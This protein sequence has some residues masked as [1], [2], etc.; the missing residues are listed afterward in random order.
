MKPYFNRTRQYYEGQGKY[1]L[2]KRQTYH[3]QYQII[4]LKGLQ[5]HGNDW[6]NNL[7]KLQKSVARTR[8]LNSDEVFFS[9]TAMEVTPVIEV[10]KIVGTGE[11]GQVYRNLG[12]SLI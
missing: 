2:V 5:G 8:L 1:I 12:N 11:E 10:K 9:G 7:Y 3:L 4:Y 6:K